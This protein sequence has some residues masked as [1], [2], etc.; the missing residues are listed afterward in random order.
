MSCTAITSDTSSTQTRDG[1]VLDETYTR[2]HTT[3]PEF[4]GWLSNHGPM[5]AD[6]CPGSRFDACGAPGSGR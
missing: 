2:M 5:A 4:E 1:D 6:A 3:G